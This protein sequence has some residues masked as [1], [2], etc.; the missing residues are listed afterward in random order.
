MIEYGDGPATFVQLMQTL[1]DW[2]AKKEGDAGWAYVAISGEGYSEAVVV[3]VCEE[4]GQFCIRDI[5][6]GRP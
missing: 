4:G 1:E 5:E 2:P 3:V 6:W